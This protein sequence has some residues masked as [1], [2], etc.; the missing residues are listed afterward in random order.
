MSISYDSYVK[1]VANRNWR[2]NLKNLDKH[3]LLTP[4]AIFGLYSN[5]KSQKSLESLCAESNDLSLGFEFE[6]YSY[7]LSDFFK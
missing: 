2:K 6:Q 3:F 5:W 1:T 4:S 7:F